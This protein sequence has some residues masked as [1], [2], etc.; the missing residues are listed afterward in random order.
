M[1]RCFSQHELLRVKNFDRYQRKLQ[2]LAS[3]KFALRGKETV[4]GLPQ[5]RGE[6]EV[7]D[8]FINNLRTLTSINRTNNKFQNS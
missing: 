6:I 5:L 4:G 2:Y 3:L 7:R 8:Y 1:A